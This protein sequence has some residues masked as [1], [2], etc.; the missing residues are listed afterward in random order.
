MTRARF[1][2]V[3]DEML[4]R[5]DREL[6]VVLEDAFPGKRLVGGKYSMGTQSITMFMEDVT[7]Q[8]LRLFPEG[9]LLLDYFKVVFAHELGHAYDKELVD[10]AHKLDGADGSERNRLMLQI[11]EN[12]WIFARSILP[13]L[14]LS[15]VEEIES[16]S[17][18]PY[19]LAVEK[20]LVPA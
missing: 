7:E 10:L 6:D 11:E 14:A 5:L 4:G 8:C 16:Q 12:A 17:L 20:D 18:A 2:N 9:E 15:F 1:Q 3:V 13:D 19:Y